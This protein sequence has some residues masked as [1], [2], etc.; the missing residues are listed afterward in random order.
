MVDRVCVSRPIYKKVGDSWEGGLIKIFHPEKRPEREYSDW[1][2]RISISW[3]GFELKKSHSGADAYQALELA[4]RLVP[5]LIA[6]TDEFH[7]RRIA[8][9]GGEVILDS[10][11]IREFFHSRIMGDV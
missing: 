3:P 6:A 7:E 9:H 5:S 11:T 8:V 1:E 4:M 2:C 10:T